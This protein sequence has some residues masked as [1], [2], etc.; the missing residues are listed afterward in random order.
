[1]SEAFEEFDRPTENKKTDEL[2]RKIDELT[3]KLEAA[4]KVINKNN[5]DIKMVQQKSLKHE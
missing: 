1:M 2:I 3:K 5:R 4:E